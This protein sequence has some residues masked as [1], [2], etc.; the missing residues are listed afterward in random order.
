MCKDISAR[1]SKSWEKSLEK[2][3]DG[4]PLLIWRGRETQKSHSSLPAPSEESYHGL[5]TGLII[6]IILKGKHPARKRVR[7]AGG[8]EQT[9][10]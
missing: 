5:S 7:E 3:N 2:G 4:I 6:F 9:D 8:I 1:S 10:L